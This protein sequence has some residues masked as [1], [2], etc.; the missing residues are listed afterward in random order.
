LLFLDADDYWDT[1]FLATIADLIAQFRGQFICNSLSRN[2]FKSVAL[3][4]KTPI[5]ENNYLYRAVSS[6]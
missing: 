1:N 3:P 5:H 6:A 4:P 2:L